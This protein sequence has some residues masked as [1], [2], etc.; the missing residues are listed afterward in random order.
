M[1]IKDEIMVEVVRKLNSLNL[2]NKEYIFSYETNTRQQQ[3]KLNGLVI[4]DTD[5]G[6]FSYIKKIRVKGEVDI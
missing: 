2:H 5:N 6:S 4:L 3:I 1:Y